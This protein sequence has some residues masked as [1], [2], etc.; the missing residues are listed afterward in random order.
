M[1]R[2]FLLENTILLAKGRKPS[3]SK[4]KFCVHADKR[5]M[6]R[7]M[8]SHIR[9]SRYVFIIF[10]IENSC[11]LYQVLAKNFKYFDFSSSRSQILNE[12]ATCIKGAIDADGFNLY[13]VSEMHKDFYK[14]VHPDKM[15]EEE[16]P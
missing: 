15:S 8:T 1:Y 7:E 6:L 12:L 16:L 5:A 11:F 13:I 3:L 9:D 4:W 2:F 14:Y 10:L